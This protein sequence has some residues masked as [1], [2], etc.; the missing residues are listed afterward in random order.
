M[1][2]GNSRVW[3]VRVFLR[4]CRGL[5]LPGGVSSWCSCQVGD[6]SLGGATQNVM[7]LR[8]RTRRFCGDISSDRFVRNARYIFFS[9]HPQVFISH[10]KCYLR[11]KWKKTWK[12]HWSENKT[13]SCSDTIFFYDL[14]SKLF[15]CSCLP[16]DVIFFKKKRLFFF[17]NLFFSVFSSS[18]PKNPW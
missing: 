16:H 3:E 11:N 15:Q 10:I 9:F 12:Y 13:T 1:L 17:L 5:L 14:F 7:F 8:V 2:F 4:R 6:L 18:S